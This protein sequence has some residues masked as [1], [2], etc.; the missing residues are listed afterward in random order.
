MNDEE[1]K[2]QIKIIKEGTEEVTSSKKASIKALKEIG[3]LTE[4]GEPS[5]EYYPDN[6]KDN[7]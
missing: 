5:K 3:L 1:I 2:E 6:N 7:Q 4:S